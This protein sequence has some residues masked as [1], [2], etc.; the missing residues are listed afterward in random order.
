MGQIIWAVLVFVFWSVVVPAA[1][2]IGVAVLTAKKNKGARPV[3]KEA[4][5]FPTATEGRALPVLF[6]TRRI[7]SPNAISP[8]IEFVA[9]AKKKRTS[10]FGSKTIVAYYYYIGLHMGLCHANIDGVKQIWMAETCLW[11]TLD[12]P[13]SIAADSQTT[14]AIDEPYCW[15]DWQREG[16]F[17]GDI[18]IQYGGS[19]QTLDSYLSAK[20][21]ATEPAYRG[22]TGLIMAYNYIGTTGGLKP[23]SAL[24]KR[25]ALLTDGSAMWYIGKAPVGANGDLNAIHI[26]YEMLTSTIIGLGKDTALIGSSFTT[27]A[28]TCYTEGYGLSNIWDWSP[29]DIESMI[30]EIE[31]IIDGKLYIDAATGKFEIG[32]IRNDYDAGT[33]ETFG[34][35]DFWVESEPTSSPGT[36]PSKVVVNWHDRTNLQSRPAFDDDIALLARQGGDPVVLELDYS[37]FVCSATLANK[38]AARDQTAVSAMPK[39]LVLRCLRT[40]SHLYETAVFKISYPALNITSMIVRVLKIDRGSLADGEC[41]IDVLE[42]VFGQ[43]FTVYGSPPASAATPAS[44]T[45]GERYWDADDYSELTITTGGSETGP[46]T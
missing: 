35:D 9:K 15:G 3:G 25:T 44:E 31:K 7:V 23:L 26:I 40:M 32:M 45:E 5:K 13:T 8:L 20:L 21:G 18:H 33:L 19:S 43:A 38:I 11:P 1:I 4:F 16:G 37:A 34:V 30:H 14:A 17:R 36:V 24:C 39:R 10:T 28:D 27:A 2:A 6:G 12:D 42:D 22:F 46:Y 29:D 41:I